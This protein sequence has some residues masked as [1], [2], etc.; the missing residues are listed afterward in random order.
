MVSLQHCWIGVQARSLCGISV[1][2]PDH[3]RDVSCGSESTYAINYGLDLMIPKRRDQFG[4]LSKRFNTKFPTPPRAL[5]QIL[6][7]R[8]TETQN[9]CMVLFYSEFQLRFQA[10]SIS[11][12]EEKKMKFTL[13]GS[14]CYTTA[15]IL[16]L[17]FPKL[18]NSHRSSSSQKYTIV[19]SS[20]D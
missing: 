11:D 5:L 12:H 16:D 20:C 7:I 3:C 19:P 9:R 2:M 6:Q 18:H 1:H 17:H 4:G 14:S 13:V 10:R 8:K 15:I